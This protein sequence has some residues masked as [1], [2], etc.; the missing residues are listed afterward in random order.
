M[1]T[2]S[3]RRARARKP[4]APALISPPAPAR[5]RR[6]GA[7]NSSRIGSL[8][9]SHRSKLGKARL[10]HAIELTRKVLR[11]PR[12]PPHRHRPGLRHRRGRDGAVVAARRPAGDDARLG[13]LRRGL[14]DRRRQAAEA[15][16]DGASRAPYGELPDLARGRSGERRRLHLERHH[17]GRPRARRRLDRRRP[18]G[19]DHLRRDLGRLR[20]G[21]ALGQ[22]RCRHLQLAEGA[23]RRGRPRHAD[24][25][26]ARGRAAGK[27][28]R[29]PGRCPRSSG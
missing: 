28:R 13:E 3:R 25:R 17:L 7:P 22:A 10:A 14:G 26:P 1:T 18:R 11:V 16:R 6:A 19:P 27:L 9:R 21:P 5:S 2:T 12:T 20:A 4:G 8:G 29:P 24:P 15:R 23:G